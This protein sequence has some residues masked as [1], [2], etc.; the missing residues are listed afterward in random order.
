MLNGNRVLLIG[1]LRQLVGVLLFLSGTAAIAAA[2]LNPVPL[3]NEPLVPDATKPGGAAFT[4]T[5]NGSGFVSGSA[6][7]WN[8]SPR[9][10]TFVS[11]SQLKASIL[12]TDIASAH[13]ASVTVVSPGPGGGTSNVVFFPITRAGSSLALSAQTT[14]GPLAEVQIAQSIAV[15]DFNRDGKLDIAASDSNGV[16]VFSGNGNGTFQPVVEYN[17]GSTPLGIATG[18]FNGD[19]K[20]D[21]AVTNWDGGNVSVL[22]GNGDGTFQA[23]VDSVSGSWPTSVAVAD[24]NGDGRLDLAVT[25]F[26]GGDVS[27]LL[28]NGDGTFQVPVDYAT[29]IASSGIAVEDLNGDGKPDLVVANYGDD[30]ISVLLGNGDGTFETAVNYGTGGNTRS[31]AV[32]DFNGDGKLD[33]VSNNAGVLLGNGDGTFQAAV[34]Y[35]TGETPM[36]V[37]V[38]DFNGDG[39][40]DLVLANNSSNTTSVLLG[41]GDGSFQENQDFGPLSQPYS[42]VVG[43]FNGDGRLDIAA[44][45]PSVA[46]Q[47]QI[48]V[49]A[50]SSASL[51]FANGVVGTSSASQTVTLTNTSGLTMNIASIAVTGTN[52]ADFVQTHTCGSSLGI[53][54]SCTIT[55]SFNPIAAGPRSASVTITDSALASPQTI[56]LS[57]TGLASGAN[58]TLSPSILTFLTQLVATTS[59]AQSVTLTNYGTASLAISSISAS[60]DFSQTHTCGSTLAVLASC[61]IS[62]TFNPTL[63]GSRSG[64]LSISDNAAGS[65]QPAILNGTGTVVEFNPSSL[66]FGLHRVGDVHSLSTTL[67]NTGS[68]PLSITSI[69]I[70]GATAEFNQGNSCGSTVPAQGSCTISVNFRAKSIAGYSAEISVA[71]DGGGALKSC[72]YRAPD[73]AFPIR[74]AH[75]SRNP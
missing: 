43:D 66:N 72:L 14:L 60:G 28:G 38:G 25:H 33:L 37:A 19:G 57:G 50:I 22:L 17:A 12:A 45:S 11:H 67:T 30:D 69:T 18:D 63:R 62:V 49:A 40:L 47:L 41:N 29:G 64:I 53:G 31:V 16:Y 4:L 34:A 9:T 61:T 13:T 46:I 48:P 39:K 7:H 51:A 32:G 5:V 10:T 3:I 55:V 6:V 59:A 68:T 27:V 35:A 1:V 42:I 73:V 65:P 70:S 20:L 52:P 58:A 24:F 56:A 54:A 36:S 8:G 15:G 21:L 71:D 75:P 23:P 2:A 26:N 74:F 44:A